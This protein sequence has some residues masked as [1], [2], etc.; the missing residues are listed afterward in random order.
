[1]VIVYKK[2][3]ITHI[4]IV[5]PEIGN[6]TGSD[7][8]ELADMLSGK[9]GGL[10]DVAAAMFIG[11]RQ[12]GV[13]VSLLAPNFKKIYQRNA[14][15][16]E[17]E[18]REK[19][20]TTDPQGIN[21]IGS[22][23]FENVPKIYGNKDANGGDLDALV[24]ARFQENSRHVLK[25]LE[26][27]NSGRLIADLQ[28]F[29]GSGALAAYA[30]SRNMAI[31]QTLHNGH[32]KHVPIDYYQDMNLSSF[33]ENLFLKEIN[34]KIHISQMATGVKNATKLK[35]VGFEF[36]RRMY[37][38][39]LDYDETISKELINEI[40]EKHK[41]E[42]IE[43][44]PNSISPKFYPENQN[45][46]RIFSEKT[47][48]ILEAKNIN[49]LYL[50]KKVGLKEDE[51][52][53]LFVSTSRLDPTQKGVQHFANTMSYIINKY[54][55]VQFFI[56]GDPTESE[57]GRRVKEDIIRAAL[58]SNGRIA[59][60]PFD[61]Q[62]CAITYAAGADSFGASSKEPFGQ[63][64]VVGII[65]GGTA[66]NNNV[67]GYKDKIKPITLEQIQAIEKNLKYFKE[68]VSEEHAMKFINKLKEKNL[69]GNGF[70]FNGSDP[71]SLGAGLEESIIIN[72]YFRDDPDIGN[73]HARLRIIDTKNEYKLDKMIN[74]LIRLYES[75]EKEKID[76]GSWK[77]Y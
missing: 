33:Y 44:V 49:K 56:I 77:S 37:S 45:I 14:K 5:T 67:D 76:T 13:Q 15:L 59:Y 53:I 58:A 41:H 9:G 74:A 20:H 72:R 50:Q 24:C 18:W 38:G 62:L 27:K 6:L 12:A 11:L 22:R 1:M 47:G 32:E 51:N 29:F 21:L 3:P 36:I 26:A 54:E 23:V 35:S 66:T 60:A 2:P 64:D 39:E 16:T 70:L 17:E 73:A 40:K 43:C 68:P 10:G 52:A 63:N 69:Y 65:N 4:A 75:V 48:N 19:R 55:D 61:E 71:Y 34:N 7:L 8:G 46:P 28:D 30:K 42:Q 57:E 31:I 25:D